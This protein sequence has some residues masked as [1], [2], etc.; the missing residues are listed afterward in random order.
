MGLCYKLQ[1][2]GQQQARQETRQEVETQEF[3]VGYSIRK[4]EIEMCVISVTLW[5]SFGVFCVPFH[6]MYGVGLL[7][8]NIHQSVQMFGI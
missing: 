7:C 6:G 2:H 5:M 1:H 4:C 8:R 3:Q